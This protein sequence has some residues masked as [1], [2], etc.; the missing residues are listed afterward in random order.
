MLKIAFPLVDKDT[1]KLKIPI[2]RIGK[3]L[4]HA[5]L[6]IMVMRI[7]ANLSA[8][9][10]DRST[11]FVQ[12]DGE[13]LSA[14]R[15]NPL[16]RTESQLKAYARQWFKTA[17]TWNNKIEGH[18]D[19]QGGAYPAGLWTASFGLD[20]GIR[21]GWL[22]QVTTRYADQLP[23]N[24]YLTGSLEAVIEL[25]RE[26][27]IQKVDEGVWRITIVADRAHVRSNGTSQIEAMKIILTVQATP[28][29]NQK[30]K[31]ILGLGKEAD[32][33]NALVHRWRKDGL[34]IVLV[35]VK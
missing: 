33:L 6:L 25:T 16:H 26:P 34:K 1:K 31:N 9:E 27:T 20:L 21:E 30:E 23:L 29:S 14:E 12:T 3:Y 17:Y 28:Q 35:E 11:V 18:K 15:V 7:G 19:T 13:T 32:S 24:S 2:R 10:E 8:I 4:Y 22:Q 5:F